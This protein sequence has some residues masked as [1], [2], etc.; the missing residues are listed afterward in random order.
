MIMV[1]EIAKM[2]GPIGPHSR[3]AASDFRGEPLC[4]TS[5]RP[6]GEVALHH[7]TTRSL[8]FIL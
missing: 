1:P 5:G 7:F 8:L 6:V 3:R 2:I 4:V